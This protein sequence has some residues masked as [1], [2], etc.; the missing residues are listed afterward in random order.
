MKLLFPVLFLCVAC[1]AALYQKTFGGKVRG[2]FIGGELGLDVFE[3]YLSF[4]LDIR[5][6]YNIR[7]LEQSELALYWLM[8]KNA[9][10]PGYLTLETSTYP[11][12]NG[13]VYIKNHYPNK[14]NQFNLG[15]EEELNLLTLI[16]SEYTDPVA[17]SF[18][19]GEIMNFRKQVHG[20][21]PQKGFG[22]MGYVITYGPWSSFDNFFHWDNWVELKWK[23][24]G[25]KIFEQHE[26]TWN[27][28]AGY[29][30]HENDLFLDALVFEL[31][32]S[33]KSRNKKISLVENTT[34]EITATIAPEVPIKSFFLKQQFSFIIGMHYPLGKKLFF[35]IST[36]I[37]RELLRT[38]EGRYRVNYQFFMVPKLTF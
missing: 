34:F 10:L 6:R 22:L 9:F 31:S 33:D 5:K 13:S 4:S 8:L 27:L 2:R 20:K 18:F 14:Y 23:I 29:T 37:F 1:K 21:P 17:F 24:K 25:T 19:A 32:R 38:L 12:L 36:G 28:V 30:F 15:G 35:N 11:L 26:R 7:E 3:P 16:S